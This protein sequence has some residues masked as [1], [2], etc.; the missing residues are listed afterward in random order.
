MLVWERAAAEK[1]RD[2]LCGGG[3]EPFVALFAPAVSLYYLASCG[4]AWRHKFAPKL[5]S[6]TVREEKITRAETTEAETERGLN[7]AGEGL[8]DRRDF[9]AVAFLAT[10]NRVADPP[11]RM[12][13]PVIR[14][15][16]WRADLP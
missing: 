2:G 4:C 16:L 1:I 15:A 5:T 3:G 11:D 14:C 13:A 6:R 8:S 12:P 9:N 10:G 7:L